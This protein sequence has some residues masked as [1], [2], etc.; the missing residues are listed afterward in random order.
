MR[1]LA[2]RWLTCVSPRP[3]VSGSV[4]GQ[5]RPDAPN[6]PPTQRIVA[7]RRISATGRLP[8]SLLIGAVALMVRLPLMF[9]GHPALTPDSPGYLHLANDLFRGHGFGAAIFSYRPPGYPAFIAFT[10]VFGSAAHSVVVAQHLIGIAAAVVVLLATWR[11]FG[12]PAAIVAALLAAT[13]PLLVGIEHEVMSD[14]LFTI[15]VFVG[16]LTLARA[17]VSSH[18]FRRFLGV[19]MLFGFATL[20]KPVGQGLVLITPVVLIIT[21]R[22]W[23]RCAR[24]SLSVVAGMAIV[25]MPWVVH[26]KIVFHHAAVSTIG[27][28]TSFWRAFDAPGRSVP[29]VGN[30]PDTRMVRKWYADAARGKPSGPVGVYQVAPRLHGSNVG[31]EMRQM[32]FRAVAA[33]PLGYVTSSVLNFRDFVA[34]SRPMDAA[35]VDGLAAAYDRAGSA[36]PLASLSL[37]I[38]SLAKWLAVG[39]CVLSGFGIFG[40]AL[41]RSRD[42]KVQVAT[43]ALGAT[44]G[45]LGIV[46]ALTANRD[47]RYDV[48][49][50]LPI[51]MVGSAGLVAAT[52]AVR[53]RMSHSRYQFQ[54]IGVAGV[55]AVVVSLVLAR[56]VNVE[57]VERD[58]VLGV[59]RAQAQGDS[60]RIFASLRGCAGSCQD[61][62]RRDAAVFRGTGV[63][64]I[65]S[66]DSATH[67]SFAG[68]T[69]QTRVA[70]ELA[71]G[72]PVVQCVR[73]RRSGNLLSG[74]SVTLLAL[75]APIPMT[76]KCY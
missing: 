71:T 28:Y 9:D 23:R 27:D 22:G 19:G 30:D 59:L 38:V 46:T 49:G 32:A 60:P 42:R 45:V 29:F 76:A 20:V 4:V 16:A 48:V 58:A 24:G 11:Y 66:T 17:C 33:D 73:V 72:P 5:L 65:L 37:R 13:A 2:L 43:T 15:L 10:R 57:N 75:S 6:C 54:M 7:G 40:L 39:W 64:K 51:L 18:R 34:V 12:Q 21:G 68:A 26:N 63:V 69:G 14:Y 31:A 62:V 25:V 44:W 56:F 53:V 35:G 41:V 67:Y 8:W 50:F 1:A 3:I 70:W 61:V 36:A 55:I 52:S 74:I 47:S